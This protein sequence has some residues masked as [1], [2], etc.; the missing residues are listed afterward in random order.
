ML[1]ELV[2]EKV[3]D[4]DRDR[5]PQWRHIMNGMKRLYGDRKVSDLALCVHLVPVE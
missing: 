1:L 4:Y 2:D 5:D 3:V